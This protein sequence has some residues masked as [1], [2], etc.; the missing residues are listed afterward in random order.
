MLILNKI[1]QTEFPILETL[2]FQVRI[3]KANKT[4]VVVFFSL[5][6]YR[7]LLTYFTVCPCKIFDKTDKHFISGAIFSGKW[8]LTAWHR[9]GTARVV[10]WAPSY[11][12][13]GNN[14]AIKQYQVASEKLRIIFFVG[15]VLCGTWHLHCRQT[16]ETRWNWGGGIVL[17]LFD[18][19]D[20]NTQRRRRRRR[21][22][23][24]RQRD[25]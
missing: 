8:R 12:R 19:N 25:R 4:E 10:R 21:R 20:A 13:G 22:H 16:S 6:I 3:L 11:G 7:F 5:I 15:R 23:S 2:Y 9:L 14:F 17:L 24:D 18:L 1:D